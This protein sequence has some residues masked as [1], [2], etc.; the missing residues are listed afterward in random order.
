MFTSRFSNDEGAQGGTLFGAVNKAFTG[1]FEQ[2]I[3]PEAGFD[4]STFDVDLR[5]THLQFLLEDIV[6]TSLISGTIIAKRSKLYAEEYDGIKYDRVKFP[7][8]ESSKHE[9]ASLTN[10]M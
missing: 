9:F 3:P 5:Q 6:R 10:D 8:L 1:V 7:T 2:Y 4:L